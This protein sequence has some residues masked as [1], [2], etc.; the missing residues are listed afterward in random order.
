MVVFLPSVGDVKEGIRIF[1]EKYK[2]RAYPLYA[3]QNP[4]S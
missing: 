1:Q 2:K 3:N 4:A